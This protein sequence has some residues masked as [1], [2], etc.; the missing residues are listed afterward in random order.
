MDLSKPLDKASAQEINSYCDKKGKEFAINIKTNQIRNVFSKITSIRNNYSI[1]R[2]VNEKIERDLIL[3]KP[4]L[5]YSAGRKA[6]VKNFQQEMNKVID[7]V[8]NSTDKNLALQNFFA[9]VEGFVAYHK[10]YGGR[11]N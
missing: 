10:F 9:I 4:L 1:K 8:I 6:E 5:A 7:A 11:D 2:E 3:L